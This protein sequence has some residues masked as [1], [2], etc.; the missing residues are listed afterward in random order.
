MARGGA[1][2]G[3]GR[4]KGKI[5]QAKRALAEMAKEHA[6]A[7]LR[8]L[9]EIATGDGAESARVSASTAIL[10]RAYGKP[11][12]AVSLGGP[13]NTRGHHV[14]ISWIGEDLPNPKTG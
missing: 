1:R 5:S 4:K 11:S 8:T 10:D 9:V 14:T 12:Q 13:D 6:E 7:A 3:A 2:P